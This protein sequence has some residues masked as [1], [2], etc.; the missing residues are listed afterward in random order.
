M[1][2]DI[3]AGFLRENG[4]DDDHMIRISLD[5]FNNR[6]Y[7]N[8]NELNDYIRGKIINDGKTNYVFIDE[9][10]FVKEVDNP[11]L[12]GGKVGFVDVVLGL[13]KI[14]HADIYVI[15]SNSE[16][17]SKNILTKFRG[18]G[19]QIHVCPLSYKE[20]YDAYAG[21]KSRSWQEYMTFGGMPRVALI[22]DYE[23]KAEY[24]KNLFFEIYIKDIME[25]N[26]IRNDK[27]VLEDLLNIVSS[28]VGSLTNPLKL[29]RA[30]KSVRK[31]SVSPATL[32]RYLECF[33]DLFL[34]ERAKRYDIRGK[35]YIE[36]PMKYYFSDIGLRNARLNFAEIEETRLMENIIY[37]ELR[38]RGFNVDV[39]V[40]KRNYKDAEG[41]SRRSQLEV[42]FVC[43]KDNERIYMQSA[44]RIDGK[45]KMDQETRGLLKIGDSFK[46]IMVLRD[47]IVPRR[48]ENGILFVGVEDFLLN[49]KYTSTDMSV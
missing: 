44:F 23:D 33:A 22:D 46:K 13:M 49:D 39:G 34:M 6:R 17:L 41:K 48:D 19:D 10:Q 2:F 18:R 32:E 29:S 5:D 26:S 30:F 35:K 27:S 47:N 9:I 12:K 45:D 4:V 3:Y 21:E 37:D 7:W 28:S 14:K 16:M 15:G 11:Y 1:L 24:L 20:F 43:N 31:V 40:V 8:P 38:T 36:S 25:S 42:D